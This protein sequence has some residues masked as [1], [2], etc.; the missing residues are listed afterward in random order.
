[1]KLLAE[2]SDKTVGIGAPEKLQGNYQLR[3]SAR[4]ILINE[5]GQ[6]AVQHLKNHYFY[7]L[8]GGG[9]D[10]GET[11]EEALRREVLEEVGCACAITKEIG[12]VIEYREKYNLLHISYGFVALVTGEINEPQFEAAEIAAGQTNIWVTPTEALALIKNATP[13][14]YESKFI[15]PREIAFLEEYI[16]TK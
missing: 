1:M 16:Q 12:V 5:H 3:K 10:E 13:D 9:V 2:I 14:K 7:K 8:P 6:I 11:V 4:A 15:I